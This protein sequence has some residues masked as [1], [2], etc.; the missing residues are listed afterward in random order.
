MPAHGLEKPTAKEMRKARKTRQ[1]KFFEPAE[2]KL[3]L[4]H[5]SPQMRAM[6]LLA[7]NCGLGNEDLA[8][9]KASNLKDGWLD[10]P[11]VKTEV[12]RRVPLFPETI[13]ALAAI[14]VNADGYVFHTKYGNLWTK[15]NKKDGTN[16]IS[17]RFTKLCKNLDLYKKGRG[18]YSLRHTCATIGEECGDS[19]AIE[20]ILGHVPLAED[21]SVPYRERMLDER[22]RKV[23][24]HIR[25]WAFAKSPVT[26]GA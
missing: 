6:I 15:P 24:E 7:L 25:Q 19:K 2:I 23:T 9:L 11:R 20:F 22:L 8:L 10:Y 21:M 3:L 16:P 17:D 13:A 14:P 5:A 18:F 1:A 12:D 4:R 26:V